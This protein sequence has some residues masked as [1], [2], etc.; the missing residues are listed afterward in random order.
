LLFNFVQVRVSEWLLVILPN[1]ILELQHALLPSKCCELGSVP[2]LFFFLLFSRYTR[3]WIY[4]RT[5]EHISWFLYICWWRSY[6]CNVKNV[7]LMHNFAFIIVVPLPYSFYYC[8]QRFGPQEI[9]LLC[10]VFEFFYVMCMLLV[11]LSL[12]S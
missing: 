2:Q 5:W 6:F 12:H 7:D 9:C 10:Y 11:N 8:T 3:I 4:L 1:L